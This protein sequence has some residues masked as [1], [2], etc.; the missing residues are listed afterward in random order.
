MKQA[1]GSF[2]K[3]VGL[4]FFLFFLCNVF[5][6][7]SSFYLF[8]H[9]I[10]LNPEQLRIAAPITFG[11]VLFLTVI[12]TA[13]YT[14]RQRYT[15]VRPAKKIQDGLDRITRGDFTGHIEP[16]GVNPQLDAIAESINRMS[17]ELKSVETLKTD[18]I[19]NVSHEIKTPLAVIQNYTALLQSSGLTDKEREAYTAAVSD[20][21]GRLS[22]LITNI[23][24]LNRLENQQIQPNNRSFDLSAA[25]TESLL[26]FEPVWEE[27]GIEIRPEIAD[28]VTVCSDPELLSLV[29]NNLLSNAFKFTEPDGIVS[30]SLRQEDRQAVV[31]VSDTG[32]GISP[33]VG[34]HIFDR[35]YQGDTSHATEGNG[36]GLALVKRVIDI[37]GS[38]IS[39][40]SI[41]GNGSTFTVRINI[42]NNQFEE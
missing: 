26:A 12:V 35:F 28:N 11:N 14:V 24:K 37:T 22:V 30:V 32:C 31:S 4:T 3:N 15:V 9:W 36:L 38:S 29:W 1:N 7:T 23:L 13:V 6:I 41:K 42:S 5:V 17:A 40:D 27:K 18:F 34:R 16:S 20:A 10:D 19:S 39:V 25:L 8:F 33:E 2:W 21:A